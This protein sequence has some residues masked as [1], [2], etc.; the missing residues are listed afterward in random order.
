MTEKAFSDGILVL[1]EK[2]ENVRQFGDVCT[3]SRPII[4]SMD[5]LFNCPSFPSRRVPSIFVGFVSF[6][7]KWCGLYG[8][9]MDTPCSSFHWLERRNFTCVVFPHGLFL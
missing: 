3:F 9:Q 8:I 1:L 7:H 4:Q 6:S 5:K 2:R